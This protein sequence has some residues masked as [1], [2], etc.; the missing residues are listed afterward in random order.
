MRRLAPLRWL[1]AITVNLLLWATAAQ[2]TEFPDFTKLVE[3]QST[4][5]ISINATGEQRS[6]R[7]EFPNIPIPEDSPLYDYFKRFFEQNPDLPRQR[8]LT[9]VGSGFI[10]SA[11]G[12]ILTNAHVVQDTTNITVGLSDRREFPAKIIGKDSRSDIALLKVEATDLPTVKIGDSN[13]LKVGQW[14]LAIGS[15]FGFERSATAGIISALGR[16]LPSD[17]YVPFIQTDAAVNPG[18]SGGPLF[19]LDGEVIGINSQIYSRTGG[20]QGVSFAIPIDVVMDAVEQLKTHGKVSRGWLGVLIQEITAELAQSFGLDKPRGAL[21]GQVM[22]DSPAQQAGIKAGDIIVSYDGQ[23]IN[24]S[25]DLP[26]L[27]GRTRPGN[28]VSLNL[29]RE[30]KEQTLAVKIQELPEDLQRQAAAETPARN[31]LNITVKDLSPERRS[32]MQGVLVTEVNE[33]PAANAGIQTGD[34]IM[35]INGEDITDTAQFETLVKKLPAG[36]PLRSLIQRSNARLFV[37]L[38]IPEGK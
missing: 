26:P 30:G 17:N 6:E 37:A 18:N 27:V 33:G 3:K 29:I 5:V 20:Y 14:V 22:A 28:T 35:N 9:S 10:I 7:F 11:D 32:T 24:H 13:K 15:P 1:V 25:S 23:P 16:S 12:Y 8:P 21:V 38:T 31:R 19:N 4:T 2:A 34:I 36:K